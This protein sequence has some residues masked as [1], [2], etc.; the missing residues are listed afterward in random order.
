MGGLLT[1]NPESQPVKKI[2]K[3]EKSV[4]QS[5]LSK[6]SKQDSSMMKRLVNEGIITAS[7]AKKLKRES[8]GEQKLMRK[9]VVDGVISEDMAQKLTAEFKLAYEDAQNS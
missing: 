5:F 8:N 2:R 9:L 6:D 7:M 4:L 1:V 3:R